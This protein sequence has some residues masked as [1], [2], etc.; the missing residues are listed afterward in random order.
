MGLR[1]FLVLDVLQGRRWKHN[2][3]LH[4]TIK[5]YGWLM[6]LAAYH[7]WFYH[8]KTRGK[9]S[10]FKVP[11]WGEWG[12]NVK[13]NLFLCPLDGSLNVSGYKFW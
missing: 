4:N 8:S 12:V 2:Y 3:R 11:R 9:G 13:E 5:H 7:Y 1:Q 6:T 10:G